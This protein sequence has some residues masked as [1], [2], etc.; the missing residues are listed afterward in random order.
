M[1]IY[2][3]FHLLKHKDPLAHFVWLGLVANDAHIY[4][5]AY[6]NIEKISLEARSVLVQMVLV[7]CGVK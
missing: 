7:V 5:L 6:A 3:F 1:Q 2:F 4:S